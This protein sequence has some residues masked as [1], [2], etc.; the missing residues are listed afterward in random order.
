MNESYRIGEIAR[1]A[2]VSVPTVRYYERLGLL[3]KAPRTSSGNRRY[4]HDAIERIHFVKRA[5]A[6]GLAL[7][8]IRELI[9]L[10]ARGATRRCQQVHSLLAAKIVQLDEQRAQI[11]EF[12]RALQTLA[13]QCA[14]SLRAG[15]DPDCPVM[16]KM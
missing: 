10:T 3:P 7:T 13:D 8:E 16:A 11:E 6:N 5:Q 12:R 15:T 9:T 14:E 4:P 2:G 1:L